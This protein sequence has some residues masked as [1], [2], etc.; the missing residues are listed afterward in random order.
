MSAKNS[1]KNAVSA[2]S[3]E[4]TGGATDNAASVESTSDRGVAPS[5]T[6]TEDGAG[7]DTAS[8]ASTGDAAMESSEVSDTSTLQT[9][10]TVAEVQPSLLVLLKETAASALAEGDKVGH[11]LMHDL[12]VRF[13]EIK[14]RLPALEH[15][16]SDAVRD[17][18]SK[19]KASL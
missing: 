18:V 14:M 9:I 11:A 6:A 12:E 7:L 19:L 10:E 1:T 15:E 3:I 5:S 17:F 13:G 2:E 16:L 8:A 4:K